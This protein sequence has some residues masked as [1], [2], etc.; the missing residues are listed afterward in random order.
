MEEPLGRTD[1]TLEFRSTDLFIEETE[2][3]RFWKNISDF[4]R[5]RSYF[6]RMDQDLEKWIQI[7][8]N[9][10]GFGRM[11]LILDQ[12]ICFWKNESLFGRMDQFLEEQIERCG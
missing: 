7:W 3:I 2:H 1:L 4:E 5:N 6:E 8:K 10:S 12:R 11:D 9:G